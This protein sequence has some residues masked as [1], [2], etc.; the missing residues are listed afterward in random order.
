MAKKKLWFKA[1]RYGYGWTPATW[2]GWAVV[3]IYLEFV[4]WDFLRI[5]QM[6]HSASDTARPFVVQVIIASLVLCLVSYLTG[7]KPRWRWGK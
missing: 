1:K 5:D 2:Q 3:I 6:S 7:E 4:V